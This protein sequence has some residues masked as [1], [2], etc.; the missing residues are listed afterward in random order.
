LSTT[1]VFS[2][3]VHYLSMSVSITYMHPV[4]LVY[5]SLPICFSYHATF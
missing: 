5:L 4:L 3:Y 2:T 1:Q